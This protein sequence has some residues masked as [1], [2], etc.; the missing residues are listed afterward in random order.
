MKVFLAP[1]G[2]S[3]VLIT[4]MESVKNGKLS[5]LMAIITS[6][7][8]GVSITKKSVTNDAHFHSKQQSKIELLFWIRKIFTYNYLAFFKG[9]FSMHTLCCWFCF[10]ANYTKNRIQSRSIALFR[11]SVICE[12]I[13]IEVFIFQE[14]V[15]F[16]PTYL[17]QLHVCMEPFFYRWLWLWTLSKCYLYIFDGFFFLSIGYR[18][19]CNSSFANAQIHT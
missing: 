14:L 13:I 12:C 10:Q 16:I 11:S 8:S 7:Q 2:V 4:L 18:D 9:F 17:C 5:L 19:E 3:I 1:F 6:F 15:G